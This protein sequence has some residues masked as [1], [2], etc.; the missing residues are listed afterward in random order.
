MRQGFLAGSAGVKDYWQHESDLA[1]YDATFAQRIGWK[2]DY[3][4]GELMALGWKPPMGEMLDWGCGSGVAARAF[5]DHFGADSVSGVKF[6]DRSAMA[7]AYAARRAGEKFPELP[8]STGAAEAPA[9]VL[10][11]HVLSELVP[12][13][14]EALLQFLRQAQAVVWVE[15][16]NYESSLAMIAIRERLREHFQCVAPCTHQSICGILAPGNDLHWC[17]F[18]AEPPPGVAG[19]PFWG[20][21]ARVTGVDLRSL[22]VSF[23][24]LDQRQP[25]PLLPDA[26]R[27][28]GRP[29]ICKPSAKI[30]GCDR[31]GVRERELAKRDFP[32]L[33]RQVKVGE[34]PA[35]N[36]WRCDN[37]RVL[38]FR[39]IHDPAP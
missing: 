12:E 25:A 19:D 17:H 31:Q 37:R 2:W 10:V 34:I 5:L 15:P 22:P 27:I 36:C 6:W 35:L 4:I 13:Q 1:S 7:M 30:L 14:T 9:L 28:L 38:E 33:Y 20:Q 29:R 24:V 39:P 32:E 8:V 18:F 16:G 11:S 23:L 21:F 3:V 26:M